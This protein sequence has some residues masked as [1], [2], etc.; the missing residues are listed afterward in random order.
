VLVP[1]NSMTL[2]TLS[3]IVPDSLRAVAMTTGY[4][5]IESAWV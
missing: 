2:Y 1:T 4:V 5:L 3:A